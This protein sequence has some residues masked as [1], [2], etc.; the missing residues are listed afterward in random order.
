MGAGA[1]DVGGDFREAGRG[2]RD[3]GIAAAEIKLAGKF[4]HGVG[5]D[6]H[7]FQAIGKLAVG[8]R[9]PD[10]GPFGAQRRNVKGRRR[11]EGR[12]F[13][14]CGLARGNVSHQAAPFFDGRRITSARRAGSRYF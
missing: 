3:D 4:R 8:S 7:H 13:G 9:R 12:S 2:S 14:R 11:L 5:F 1:H 10:H 6:Q